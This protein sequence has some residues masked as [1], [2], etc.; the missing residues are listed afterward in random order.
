MITT[1]ESTTTIKCDKCQKESVAPNDSYN[2]K[3]WR[4]G[5]SLNK[6]RKYE[7]LCYNCLPKKQQKAID[8]LKAKGF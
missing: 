6:G 3:F 2:E 1:G 5:W 7:H 4:E 8:N